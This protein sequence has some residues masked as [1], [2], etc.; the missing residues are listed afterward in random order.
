MTNAELLQIQV[1]NRFFDKLC[2]LSDSDLMVR[3]Q[4]E[5]EQGHSIERIKDELN[6]RIRLS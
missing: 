3:K 2:N 4:M 1:M 5:I 6:R